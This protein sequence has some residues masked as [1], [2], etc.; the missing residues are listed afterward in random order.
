LFPVGYNHPLVRFSTMINL[1]FIL[2]C[3]EAGLLLLFAPWSP[4]WDRIMMQ[5]PVLG[6]KAV[7]L[8]PGFRGAVTGFGLVH[9]VWGMHDLISLLMRCGPGTTAAA[10]PLPPPI[11]DIPPPAPATAPDAQTARDQ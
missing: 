1:F 6:L 11:P 9:L 3:F 10:P 7:L 8:H 2:Y 4:E 5:V